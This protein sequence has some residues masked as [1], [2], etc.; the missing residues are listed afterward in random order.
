MR[1]WFREVWFR[2]IMRRSLC[3]AQGVEP[4]HVPTCA[5]QVPFTVYF[6]DSAK[7]K[8]SKAHTSF[9]VSDDRFNRGLALRIERSAFGR[10]QPM[11]HFGKSAG[12]VPRGFG[13]FQ[14]RKPQ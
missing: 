5:S 4:A 3:Q 10:L 6:C 9:D 12:I 13:R 7:Q 2:S 1:D 11:A 14:C 8:L